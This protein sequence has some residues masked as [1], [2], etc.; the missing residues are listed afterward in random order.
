M[1]RQEP[2]QLFNYGDMYRDFTY[3]DD[4][5]TGIRKVMENAPGPNGDGV[6]YRLYNIGSSSPVNLLHFVEV[7][8]NCLMK[9]GV[10]DRPAQKEY[11]PMQPGD[12]YQTFA[13]V[14]DLERD[15]GFCPSTP[16]EK[17]LEQFAEWY[18]AYYADRGRK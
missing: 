17:G 16:L 3:I 8:E 18:A 1:V 9:A 15:F 6:R 13:D 7:L 14:T 4:I 12:V 2:I 10:I 5:V 11:L